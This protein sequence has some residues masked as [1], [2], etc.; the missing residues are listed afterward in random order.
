MMT[1]WHQKEGNMSH[2]AAS[3]ESSYDDFVFLV[4]GPLKYPWHVLLK[5]LQIELF[6][7]QHQCSRD[8]LRK[9]IKKSLQTILAFP[10]FKKWT[11]HNYERNLVM[12]EFATV[13]LGK[14]CHARKTKPVCYI[15]ALYRTRMLY[16]QWIESE[17]GASKK[18]SAKDAA[19]LMEMVSRS[20]WIDFLSTEFR[21]YAEKTFKNIPHLAYWAECTEVEDGA[22]G[23]N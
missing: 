21:N 8:M 14:E 4:F 1:H 9:E 18:L 2:T 15:K 20:Q 17:R 11:E 5:K 10:E 16:K 7:G 19:D 23:K 12:T 13:L 22:K 6:H 3:H